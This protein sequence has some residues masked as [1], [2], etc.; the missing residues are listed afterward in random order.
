MRRF[1]LLLARGVSVCPQGE[2]SV[3]V[4][5]HGGDGLDVHA[6]LESQGSKGVPEIMKP[7]VFQSSVLEDALMQGSHRV[8]VVHGP[9][10]GGREEPRVVRVLGVLLH[11]QFHRLPG[12]G[13]LPDRI[14]CLG[15]GND[16]L[17]VLVLGGLFADGDGFPYDA[18]IAAPPV[19]PSEFR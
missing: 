12:N 6:V 7:E 18:P 5:Q 1:V 10:S 3:I 15:A 16:Q 17:V 9:G 13:D 2:S 19:R 14:L 4:A 8:R 11:K